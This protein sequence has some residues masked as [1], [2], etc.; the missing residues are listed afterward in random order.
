[1]KATIFRMQKLWLKPEIRKKCVEGEGG[2]KGLPY[3]RVV[4]V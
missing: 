1:M 2:G 4:Q 3:L